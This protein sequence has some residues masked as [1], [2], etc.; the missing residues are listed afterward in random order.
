MSDDIRQF[1]SEEILNTD[2]PIIIPVTT[3]VLP[4]QN[5]PTTKVE[6]TESGGIKTTITVPATTP[7]GVASVTVFTEKGLQEYQT[8]FENPLHE[9]ASYTYNISL[10][11][12][13]IETYN[14]IINN[15]FVN[16]SPTP[17]VPENVLISGAGRYNDVDFK[18]NKY[19]K[20]D[21]Y[22]ED[23]RMQTV[24]TANMRNRNTN[25]IECSF[26]IIEPNGFTLINR[27]IA[28]ANEINKGFIGAPESYIKIPYVLQIDFFGYKEEG[29]PKPEKIK[30]L[31]KIIPI[32]LVNVET[33]V[34]QAGAEY[35]VEAVAFNHQ[36]F[37][38]IYN[39]IPF[40]TTISAKTVAAAFNT[41]A[42]DSALTGSLVARQQRQEKLE[43]EINQTQQI[44]DELNAGAT[45]AFSYYDYL[46]EQQL[47]LSNLKVEENNL[48]NTS[49]N[50]SGICVAINSYYE[51]L[52]KL[53]TITYNTKFRVEFDPEIAASELF[54]GPMPVSTPAAA[55]SNTSQTGRTVTSL[56]FNAGTI[57][58]PPGTTLTNL[59]DFVVRNSK[60]I[61]DQIILPD[62]QAVASLQSDAANG[63]KT[64]E[65]LITALNKPLKWY[66]I[67]P[68]L[69][70]GKWDN[71]LK[72]FAADTVIL[73][74]RTFTISSKY[75]YAAR[76]RVPGYVKKYDYLFTG[77]NKDVID[78]HI[79][80]NTLYLLAVTGNL[81]KVIQDDPAKGLNP[82]GDSATPGAVTRN[83]TVQPNTN[84]V[85]APGVVI[86]S[87]NSN[88]IVLGG[89]PQKSQASADLAN[90]IL[91]DA[92]GD[93][94]ELELKILGDPHFI[95]QDDVFYSRPG[96]N[97]SAALTPNKSLYMDSGELYIFVNFISPVDYSEE[98]GLAEIK[99]NEILGTNSVAAKSLGYSNFSGVYKLI[100]VD[101]TLSRGKFEQTLRL[102]KIL[103]DQ[104][105]QS[106][107]DSRLGQNSQLSLTLNALSGSGRINT[108]QSVADIV[109][110][111]AFIAT[112]SGI[113]QITGAITG[114]AVQVVGRVTQSIIDRGIA[115]IRNS[116]G[117]VSEGIS[118]PDQPD[119]IIY[120]S[121]TP[122][123][124]DVGFGDTT[125]ALG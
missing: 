32:C 61:Q 91:T 11:M 44:I 56:A 45:S 74:V 19:F 47:K 113:G 23:F 49:I 85:A 90:S 103:F 75:P 51:A 17:Y 72:R 83:T 1:A 98:K 54:S 2:Q 16:N 80:F 121:V 5:L 57:N 100:T 120:A 124:I 46:D 24:I 40:H 111:D 95:K 15:N 97:Q 68:T 105:G 18:R 94:I 84:P 87:G 70:V 8:E 53:G 4:E 119:S 20:E 52:V 108:A 122:E 14:R 12:I 106:I 96:A 27:M 82:A 31:T 34:R 86:T 39:A 22:F 63:R 112:N 78:W 116:T 25:M 48:I 123:I 13:S 109:A 65:E 77:R 35:K 50:A 125:G 99:A 117:S 107:N 89:N 29:D 101:S 58:I 28:A 43:R 7:S 69:K 115:A 60:Y 21:F 59:I 93:M 88:T 114:A 81:N 38:Q 3:D 73:Y 62:Q 33:Q 41:G 79:N 118:I 10:H 37:S 67:V 92:R 104:S 9:Y 64:V 102:A 42:S 30:D 71:K 66:K 110:N 6:T 55:T 36:V 26:T 76:G